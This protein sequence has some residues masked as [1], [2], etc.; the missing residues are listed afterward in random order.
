MKYAKPEGLE[1]RTAGRVSDEDKATSSAAHGRAEDESERSQL[2]EERKQN[3]QKQKKT[4]ENRKAVVTEAQAARHSRAQKPRP[5]TDIENDRTAHRADRLQDLVRPS[6]SLPR[7]CVAL[8]SVHFRWTSRVRLTL[9]FG[10]RSTHSATGPGTAQHRTA[11]KE[12][13]RT[14]TTCR[15]GPPSL[16]ARGEL[17]WYCR[18]RTCTRASGRLAVLW[19]WCSASEDQAVTGEA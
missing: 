6:P 11:T 10:S 1:K 12:A 19:L 4:E 5:D 3:R 8:L 14:V 2:P 15:A 13:K 16:S 17:G 9:L 7:L 18:Q